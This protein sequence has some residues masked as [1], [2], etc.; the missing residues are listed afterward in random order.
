LG[1]AISVRTPGPRAQPFTPHAVM[2][3]EDGIPWPIVLKFLKWSDEG[4]AFWVNVAFELGQAVDRVDEQTTADQV[5]AVDPLVL[6]RV[7]L[8]YPLY[9]KV[10]KDALEFELGAAWAGIATIKRGRGRSGLTDDFLRRIGSE[11]DDWRRRGERHVAT[12]IAKAHIVDLSTASRWI[13]KATERGFI[14]KEK[15]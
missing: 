4:E 14:K 13:K 7:A 5:P 11:V 2:I 15:P 8:Q 3:R 1:Y 6:E 9:L 12:K 10:A